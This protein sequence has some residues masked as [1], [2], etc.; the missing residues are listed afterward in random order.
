MENLSRSS[1]PDVEPSFGWIGGVL[2]LD[3]TNT[4]GNHRA[5][6]PR[7]KLA[8]FKSLIT[9]A[10]QADILDDSA[11]TE[12][13]RQGAMVPAQAERLLHLAV[14]FREG[15]YRAFSDVS[16]GRQPS[17]CDLD[18]INGLLARTPITLQV[19]AEGER[20][21]CFRTGCMLD[22][23]RLLGPV[24]WSAAELLGSNDSLSKVR[25]CAGE[26]CGWLFLDL[27][28]NHTR[29]WCDMD[30]CGSRAKAKRYYR[31][32]MQRSQEPGE[33]ARS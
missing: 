26:E 15:L 22:E 31:R 12:M 30:D 11:S 33:G 20:L 8:S 25:Q 29:R 17:K 23:A 10:R 14:D 13:L 1:D 3:F 28:K 16:Q 9:W 7:E 27:T 21:V 32:K 18:V 4:V 19:A 24:A 6:H 2:C 5:S